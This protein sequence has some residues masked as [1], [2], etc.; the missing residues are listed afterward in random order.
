MKQR[1]RPCATLMIGLSLSHLPMGSIFTVSHPAALKG[2]SYDDDTT[3]PY[4]QKSAVGQETKTLGLYFIAQ[5]EL[6]YIHWRSSSIDLSEL[7][8]FAN[9]L[10][11]SKLEKQQ[12]YS[13]LNMA[14]CK[15]ILKLMHAKM[16]SYTT[17]IMRIKARCAL[18][19]HVYFL[20]LLTASF[21]FFLWMK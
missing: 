2:D 20:D 9:Y 11:K 16:C 7:R 12:T 10:L 4:C 19:S 13:C 21:F 8:K 18:F 5:I 6:L 17:F 1:R 15:P 3:T 14:L